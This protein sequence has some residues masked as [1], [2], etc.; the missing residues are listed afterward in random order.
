MKGHAFVAA[1]AAVWGGSGQGVCVLCVYVCV[2]ARARVCLCV[3]VCCRVWWWCCYQGWTTPAGYTG[4]KQR[5]GK[6]HN[7]SHHP[8]SERQG[9]VLELGPD[10]K[11]KKIPAGATPS[12]V[13]PVIDPRTNK[14][15]GGDQ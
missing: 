10:G 6:S 5:G 8:S 11:V 15:K 2:R 12:E 14:G 7:A 1:W 3:C 4:C 9:A 13:Q